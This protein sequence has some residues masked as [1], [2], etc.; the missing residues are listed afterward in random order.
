MFSWFTQ[1]FKPAL[2]VEETNA[3]NVVEQM[4]QKAVASYFRVP[5]KQITVLSQINSIE[6]SNENLKRVKDLI[7]TNNYTGLGSSDLDHW[8]NT[9]DTLFI[10]KIEYNNVP[11]IA[12][13][14]DPLELYANEYLADI[15]EIKYSKKLNS[16]G[17][18]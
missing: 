9:D 8:Q 12:L 11:F 7:A 2:K 13:L 14:V 6:Y 18:C 10:Y 3:I 5:L 1:T 17:S 15:T 16:T 4:V